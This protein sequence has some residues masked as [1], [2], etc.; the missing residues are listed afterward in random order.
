MQVL[1]GKENILVTID[2]T[3]DAS[4]RKDANIVIGL[5]RNANREVTSSAMPGN[6]YSES[7]DSM[8]FQ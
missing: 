7:Y 5:F 8:C 4:G 6:V 1:R 2:E 3:P